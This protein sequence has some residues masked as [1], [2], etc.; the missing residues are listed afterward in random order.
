ME[1]LDKPKFIYKKENFKSRTIYKNIQI[2]IEKM[3]TAVPNNCI[4]DT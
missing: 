1:R 2:F 4:I 3:K